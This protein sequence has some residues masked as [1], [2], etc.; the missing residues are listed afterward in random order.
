MLAPASAT[1]SIALVAASMA[2]GCSTAPRVGRGFGFGFGFGFGKVSG[3][4]R[5]RVNLKVTLTLPHP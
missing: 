5:V 4:V 1:T 2:D 3:R